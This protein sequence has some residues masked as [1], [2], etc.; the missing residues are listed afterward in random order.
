MVVV[1]VEENGLGWLT[2]GVS[3][4]RIVRFPSAI[5]TVA[6]L[7][8]DHDARLLGGLDLQLFDIGEETD[9]IV[10][11]ARRGHHDDRAGIARARDRHAGEGVDRLGDAPR[12]GEIGIAQSEVHALHR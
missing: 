8:V 1:P 4:M 10:L 9:Q 7:F 2:C 5:A 6:R 11:A 12:R 3:V